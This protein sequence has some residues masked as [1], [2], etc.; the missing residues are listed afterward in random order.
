MIESSLFLNGITM[1]V[2]LIDVQSKQLEGPGKA[3]YDGN[4][5]IDSLLTTVSPLS[6]IFSVE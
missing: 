4:K 6:T 2:F 1:I 3:D 5:G